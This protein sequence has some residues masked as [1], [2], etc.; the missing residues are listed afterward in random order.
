MR[1]VEEP[2]LPVHDFELVP[3]RM[4][5]RR[6]AV[7]SLI[8]L[9][10]IFLNK[11]FWWID[12]VMGIAVAFMLFYA[13]YEI[14]RD[15]IE[16]L[17]GED[18]DNDTREE[19]KT[20]CNNVAGFDI[21]VHHVHLHQ[22]GDHKEMTYHIVLPAEMTLEKAHIIVDALEAKIKEQMGIMATTHLDPSNLP[23]HYD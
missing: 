19:L 14:L 20:L 12:A 18:I 22:Y 7:S 10:G 8:I 5:H 1:H 11:Y 6:D 23:Q 2:G 3:T 16:S 4:H 13:T 15:T 9:A 21:H 17:L